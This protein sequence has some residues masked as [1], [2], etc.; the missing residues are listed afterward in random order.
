MNDGLEAF[1]SNVMADIVFT[2]AS[3][4]AVTRQFIYKVAIMWL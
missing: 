4:Q 2:L 3:L 1:A